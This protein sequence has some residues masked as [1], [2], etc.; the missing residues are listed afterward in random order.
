[1]GRMNFGEVKQDAQD[2]VAVKIGF[3]PRLFGSQ[4]DISNSYSWIFYCV[5]IDLSWFFL[6][7][8]L[9]SP[10]LCHPQFAYQAIHLTLS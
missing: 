4:D 9:K 5:I 3:E 8:H 7:K 1:M 2:P 6:T 10:L